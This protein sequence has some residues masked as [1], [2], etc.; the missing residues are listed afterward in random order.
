M[1]ERGVTFRTKNGQCV[2]LDGVTFLRRWL[3]HVLPPRFVK[4]R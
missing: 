3:C 4:I 1:D 2:T